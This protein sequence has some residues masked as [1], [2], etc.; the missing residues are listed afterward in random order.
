MLKRKRKQSTANVDGRMPDVKVEVSG[1]FCQTRVFE[2]DDAFHQAYLL[3]RGHPL[4][5]EIRVLPVKDEKGHI[6]QDPVRVFATYTPEALAV[7]ARRAVRWLKSHDPD[8]KPPRHIQDAILA[9][10][11]AG[12][13]L[14]GVSA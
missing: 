8:E 11:T 7:A 3:S 10:Q 1:N 4:P 9:V 14:K 13:Q 2:V 5:K 6:I 12:V